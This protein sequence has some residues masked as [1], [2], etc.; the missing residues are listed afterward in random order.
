MDVFYTARKASCPLLTIKTPNEEPQRLPVDSTECDSGTS[1]AKQ[2]Q[3]TGRQSARHGPA[4]ED[5]S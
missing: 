3:P 2:I 4:T 1:T 5:V